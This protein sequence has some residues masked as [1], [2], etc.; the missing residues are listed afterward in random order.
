[1]VDSAHQSHSFYND[2]GN[3]EGYSAADNNRPCFDQSGD[4]TALPGQRV[5]LPKDTCFLLNPTDI[6]VDNFVPIQV[7][8]DGAPF[9]LAAT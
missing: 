9:S 7:T 2:G 3:G 1:M 4:Y 5:T 8:I 6:T